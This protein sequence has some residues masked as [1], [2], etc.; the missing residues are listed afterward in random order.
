MGRE[1]FP[2][3]TFKSKAQQRKE[4]EAYAAWAFPYG[5]DQQKKIRALLRE[6][7]PKEDV[8]L[9]MMQFLLGKEAF[10]DKHEENPDPHRNPLR[11]AELV[12]RGSSLRCKKQD[13]ALYLALI[14]ADARVDERLL[15]PTAAELR[16]AARRLYENE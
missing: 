13:Q 14:V 12:L 7:L 11:D 15:Y 6:L 9:A 8:S 10:C 4:Q 1:L 5:P 3:L 2:W 16:V